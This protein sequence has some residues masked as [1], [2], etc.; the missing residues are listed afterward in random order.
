[1]DEVRNQTTQHIPLEEEKFLRSSMH[2]TYSMDRM[3]H[4]QNNELIF[5][6]DSATD[7]LRPIWLDFVRLNV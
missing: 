4:I 1:M 6:F 3:L 5:E 2:I 7:Y